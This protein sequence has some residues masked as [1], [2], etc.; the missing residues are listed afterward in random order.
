MRKLLVLFLL[1]CYSCVDDRDFSTD[2]LVVNPEYSLNFVDFQFNANAINQGNL[3]DQNEITDFAEVDF[4]RDDINVDYLETVSFQVFVEN[5]INQPININ[6]NFFNPQDEIVFEYTKSIEAGSPNNPFTEQFIID[7]NVEEVTSITEAFILQASFTQPQE[8][9]Q[10]GEFSLQSIVEF[11]YKLHHNEKSF[12][13]FN[14]ID[15]F[16][17]FSSTPIFAL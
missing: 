13:Y 10:Q 5:S 8:N 6:F 15:H 3:S 9:D 16:K 12:R 2:D 1:I 17:Y 11:S 4:L 14:F 7:L